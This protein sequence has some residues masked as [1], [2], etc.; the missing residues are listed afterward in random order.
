MGIVEELEALDVLMRAVKA[1]SALLFSIEAAARLMLESVQKGGRILIVGNG[2]SADQAQHFAAELVGRFR[3][4]RTALPAIALTVDTSIITAIGNDYGFDQIFAR[5]VAALGHEGDVLVVLSTS[6]N[7]QNVVRAAE[8]AS[9]RKMKVVA[10]LGKSGGIMKSKADVGIV[11]PSA[12][13][14]RIQELHLIIIHTWCALIDQ[15]YDNA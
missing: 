5:Q 6:G 4:E 15:A 8:V 14:A 2:G 10:L 12:D 11:I 9:E 3:T 1:D 13:T 7:S